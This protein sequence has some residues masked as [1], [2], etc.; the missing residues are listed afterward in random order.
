M[1]SPGTSQLPID[2]DQCRSLFRYLNET[3]A[4][5]GCDNTLHHAQSW[6]EAHG[7]PWGRLA[8]A[9]R[10]LGGFCDC[11]VLMNVSADHEPG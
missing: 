6:A 4:L 1:S 7:V 9:L 10:G 11:E 5:Q 8:R 2:Q 3:I